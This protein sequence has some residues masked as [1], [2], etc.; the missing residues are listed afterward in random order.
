MDKGYKLIEELLTSLK[1]AHRRIDE[2]IES[3]VNSGFEEEDVED[4][5]RAAD[6]LHRHN[7][8][9]QEFIFA[10]LTEEWNAKDTREAIL[11]QKLFLVMQR[12]APN[13]ERSVMDWFAQKLDEKLKQAPPQP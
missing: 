13:E 5:K 12:T 11:K 9:L 8:L 7:L 3:L 10:T 6:K 4:V 1:T 2:E